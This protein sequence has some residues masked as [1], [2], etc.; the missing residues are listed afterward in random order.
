MTVYRDLC[1]FRNGLIVDSYRRTC[2]IYRTGRTGRTC[3]CQC[4][5][6]ETRASIAQA[7]STSMRSIRLSCSRYQRSFRI[8][9]H[10][11][12][13]GGWI[14][15]AWGESVV[16]FAAGEK[17]L[18]DSVGKVA[19]QALVRPDLCDLS[20]ESQREEAGTYQARN[21]LN[22]GLWRSWDT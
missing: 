16:L 8:A 19:V 9:T 6:R 3:V 22:G 12:T 2:A 20:R 13:L 15:Y 18:N 10:T 14:P 21:H 17:K 5:F 4:V 11:H 7:S 1:L